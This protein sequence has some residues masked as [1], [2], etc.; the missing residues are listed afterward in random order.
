MEKVFVINENIDGG[1]AV[2]AFVRMDR[3]LVDF[4]NLIS[5]DGEITAVVLDKKENGKYGY[6]LGF[7]I[8]LKKKRNG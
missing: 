8:K 6:N 2:G 3:K 4:I 7:Y 5:E 1:E